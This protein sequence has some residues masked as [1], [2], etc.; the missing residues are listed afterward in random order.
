MIVIE[1][2]GTQW[3]AARLNTNSAAAPLDAVGIFGV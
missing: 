2:F 1:D 3:G